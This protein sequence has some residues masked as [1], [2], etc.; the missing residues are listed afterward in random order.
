[1]IQSKN[2]LIVVTYVTQ[3]PHGRVSVVAIGVGFV[4]ID[5]QL[6]V[7]KTFNMAGYL[8]DRPRISY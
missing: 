8:P 4:L 3:Q 6:K 7:I 2:S 5:N 1:M